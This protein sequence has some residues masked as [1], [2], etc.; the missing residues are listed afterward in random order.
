MR[1]LLFVMKQCRFVRY[2]ATVSPQWRASDSPSVAIEDSHCSEQAKK[3][4]ATDDHDWL[5]LDLHAIHRFSMMG[6]FPAERDGAGRPAVRDLWPCQ[7]EMNWSMV[8]GKESSHRRNAI[9]GGKK[10]R[11]V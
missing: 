7:R 10:R 4:V 6:S 3:V 2:S 5:V 1:Q 11:S 9:C 8:M